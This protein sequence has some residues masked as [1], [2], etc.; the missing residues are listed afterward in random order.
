MLLSVEMST[1]FPRIP[2]QRGTS[3]YPI[4]HDYYRYQYV[5]GLD[6]SF[7]LLH[8]HEPPSKVDNLKMGGGGIKD[9]QKKRN[10]A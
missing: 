1:Y 2:L 7:F 10:V 6:W 3:R 8:A 4:A 5:V 9:R